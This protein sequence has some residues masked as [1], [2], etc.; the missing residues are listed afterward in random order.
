MKKILFIVNV[1]KFFISHRLPIALECI[2]NGYEVHLTCAMTD[3][4]SYLQKLGIITHPIPLSRAGISI[5]N[6]INTCFHIYN[7]VKKI[8][9]DIVHMV[10][11]K[12][13]AYGGV[14]CKLLKIKKR[15]ASISGL[16]YA[17]I[18]QSIKAKI[19]KNIVVLLYR[20]S[21]KNK[22]TSVI[23]QNLND[24]DYFTNCG[25]IKK[26]QSVLI[27]GSGV[28]LVRYKVKPEPLGKPVVMLVS[29]LL[30]DKGIREFIDAVRLVKQKID[31]SA[32]LVGSI[33][34]NPNSAKE[35]EIMQWQNE[36]IIEY[37][38]YRDDIPE[39]LCQSNLVVLPSYREGL[40]KCL[41]EAA[42]CGRAVVTTD[43][44]GCR[45]AI[46]PN[47]TGI[48]VEVKDHITLANAIETLIINPE[49]RHQMAVKGRELAEQ[50]FDIDNVVKLHL[51]IYNSS[52]HPVN[53]K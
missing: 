46:I 12:P 6:E 35:N 30:Y 53:E 33:D 44:P 7:T 39:V 3:S 19:I 49:L 18:D 15:V 36:G 27:R 2:K 45:D 31:F 48:L 4:T 29:R 25:I 40:P 17:F 38:G 14:V 43:V 21:L 5:L 13:V 32:V 8:K 41:I 10:T 24:K 20:I 16:G 50:V 47:V 22:N 11:V 28:D 52:Y 26:H 34:A 1:D 9:P 37:W 42:A 23:F 51:E